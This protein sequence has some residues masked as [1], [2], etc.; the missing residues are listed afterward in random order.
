MPDRH[1]A[2][3]IMGVVDK[4]VD[5]SVPFG[6]ID[7]ELPMSEDAHKAFLRKNRARVSEQRPSAPPPPPP[8]EPAAEWTDAD[9]QAPADALNQLALAI[10]RKDTK[11]AAELQA[12]IDGLLKRRNASKGYRL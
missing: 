3:T 9:D 5:I 12:H 11:R 10:R 8:D 4:A 7:S 6:E 2:C 1:F